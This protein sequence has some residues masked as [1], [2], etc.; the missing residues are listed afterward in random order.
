[1]LRGCK[2][3]RSEVVHSD[4]KEI[5]SQLSQKQSLLLRHKDFT[6]RSIILP[7]H[8][9]LPHVTSCKID[10]PYKKN[11]SNLLFHMWNISFDTLSLNFTCETIFSRYNVNTTFSNVTRK[12]CCF[13]L[14]WIAVA[15]VTF[16]VSHVKKLTWKSNVEKLSWKSHICMWNCS[17]HF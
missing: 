3:R 2:G 13:H 8:P 7:P 12:T 14:T 11:T 16:A 1:M 9:P 17:S 4:Q 15:Y 5:K 10:V 6:F